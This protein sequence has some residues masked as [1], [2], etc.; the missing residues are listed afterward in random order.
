[1]TSAKSKAL[2][3]EITELGRRPMRMANPITEE[4]KKKIK[5]AQ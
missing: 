2:L 3:D 1:M 4:E 5:L